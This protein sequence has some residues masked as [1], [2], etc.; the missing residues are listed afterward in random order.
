M[1]GPEDLIIVPAR[2]G[3]KRIPRKNLI[4]LNGKPLIW[5]TL[6]HIR[7]LGL[8][9]ATIVSSDCNVIRKYCME[10]G[11]KTV[12]RPIELSTDGSP[13][14][15]ALIHAADTIADEKKSTPRWIFCLQPASPLRSIPSTLSFIR[16]SNSIC[17]KYD[18]IFSV[19][20]TR[21]DIWREKEGQWSRIHGKDA[22]RTQ[23]ER[24]PLYVETSAY[25]LIKYASLVHT[26]SILGTKACGIP[27]PTEDSLDI[28]TYEDLDYASYLLSRRRSS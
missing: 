28:N 9:Q 1:L 2:G 17:R 14:E 3:S 11:F 19:K 20:E 6:N 10:E 24:M 5:Y 26:K 25:Y 16:Q 27:V 23:S 13:T 4:P 12:R 15:D 8:A 22:P 21:D 7:E 18:S